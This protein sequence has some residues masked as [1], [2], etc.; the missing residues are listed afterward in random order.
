MLFLAQNQSV[1]MDIKIGIDQEQLSA[2][3]CPIPHAVRWW[4]CL[5]VC[6]LPV[7]SPHA[8]MYAVC[9]VRRTCANYMQSAFAPN[10]IQSVPTG[11]GTCGNV[12]SC[13]VVVRAT[14]RSHLAFT[15]VAPRASKTSRQRRPNAKQQTWRKL[16]S[17][18][19]CASG[20]GGLNILRVPSIQC[21]D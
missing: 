19:C 5:C 12:V 2:N 3:A 21:S 20:Y 11:A 9:C 13:R 7:V 6:V 16:C 17:C 1:F 15:F 10:R 14:E 18:V 4:V 8:Y